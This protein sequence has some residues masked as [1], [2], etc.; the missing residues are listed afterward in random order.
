MLISNKTSIEKI[1]FPQTYI[2]SHHKFYMFSAVS[3]TQLMEEVNHF[4]SSRLLKSC[5]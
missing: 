5:I 4:H 3:Q 2:A 1:I